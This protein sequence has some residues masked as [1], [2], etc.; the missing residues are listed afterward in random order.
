[1]TAQTAPIKRRFPWKIAGGMIALVAVAIAARMLPVSSW[2]ESFNLWVRELGG[3]GY[4]VFIAAYAG[5]TVLLI[6]GSA[7]TLGA[8]FVF[9]LIPGFL[10][11]SAASTLGASLAF[12]IARYVARERVA[13]KLGQN[14]KFRSIDRAIGREGGKIV[15]LLRL[16]PVVPFTYS[17]YLYGLTAVRFRHYVVASW[18]GMIPGTLLFVYLGSIGKAGLEAAAGSSAGPGAL[19]WTFYGIG[20]VATIAVT[21]FVTRIARKAL[22]ETDVEE[23][24]DPPR[25][26]RAQT[27]SEGSAG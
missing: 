10:T 14:Q 13:E 9:G 3:I 5:L 7:L 15:F 6:P 8:G 19:Q 23:A 4:A 12:L 26:T 2:L 16:T 24:T 17:N 20:L 22:R 18:T 27:A 25:D 21:L 1:M 11:V